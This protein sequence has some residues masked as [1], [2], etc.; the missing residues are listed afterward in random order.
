MNSC[1]QK[2]KKRFGINDCC[3]YVSVVEGGD[4][5]QDWSVLGR[6]RKKKCLSEEES[7]EFDAF[8]V[9]DGLFCFAAQF[10][11]DL[12]LKFLWSWTDSPLLRHQKKNTLG[13]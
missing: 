6:S 2:I 7:S 12:V 8:T 3:G 4:Y 5:V 9:I 13:G 1:K 11:V 10:W